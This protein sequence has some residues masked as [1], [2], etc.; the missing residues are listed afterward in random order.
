M[1]E[2]PLRRVPCHPQRL[3]LTRRLDE[4]ITRLERAH[5]EP[6]ETHSRFDKA[7]RPKAAGPRLGGRRNIGN[8][9]DHGQEN[10]LVL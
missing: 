9:E 7:G 10:A 4:G 5:E 3:E 2:K 6:A 8:I 1:R